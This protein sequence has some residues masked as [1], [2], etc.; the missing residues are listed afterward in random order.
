MTLALF[1]A[2]PA[3]CTP[4]DLGPQPPE[5]TGEINDGVTTL[6][7]RD[8]AGA[9]QHLDNTVPRI[10]PNGR[11]VAYSVRTT[12]FEAIYVRD[13]DTG[14]TEQASVASDGTSAGSINFT[15]SLSHDGRFVAFESWSDLLSADDTNENGDVYVRDRQSGTTVLASVSSAGA[16][17]DGISDKPALSAD[18]RF[19]AFASDSSNL[20]AGDTNQVADVFVRDLQSQMTTRVSV[21]SSGE[22]VM[23]DRSRASH[24]ACDISADG[25]Y[26]T[27]D[28]LGSQ[29]VA[30]DTNDQEDVFVH[31][32]LTG[33]T[34][35]VSVDSSGGQGEGN[36]DTPVISANGRIVAFIS[37]AKN[38]VTG[39]EPSITVVYLHDRDADENSVFDETCDGCRR[40]ERVP[41]EPL[42]GDDP[43]IIFDVAISGD[44]KSVAYTRSFTGPATTSPP[45]HEVYDADVNIFD[46]RTGLT[47][48]VS[49]DVPGIRFEGDIL[50]I[51]A[52][53]RQ[54]VDS[55]ERPSLSHDGR[56]VGYLGML[57]FSFSGA[58]EAMFLEDLLP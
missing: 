26:V 3:G 23:L 46:R 49:A 57:S 12:S 11:V 58:P 50:E 35:R 43:G 15:P 33:T 41:L 56:Y 36:S 53:A 13:L 38:L 9:L 25:R 37:T 52:V 51:F 6:V 10:S 47:R 20:V 27:F 45:T 4:L 54:V 32:R 5:F 40:T 30:D 39:V 21:S 8:S 16:A 7:S 2:L 14:L 24:S 28:N 44:G 17:G 55:T 29:L 42:P 34:V 22:Q 19:V 48:R 31:D 1:A 18:G